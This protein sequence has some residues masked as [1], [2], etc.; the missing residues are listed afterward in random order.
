MKVFLGMVAA[1]FLVALPAA[2]QMPGPGPA[3]PP[4]TANCSDFPSPPTLPNGA[5]AN[6]A[7]MMRGTEEYGAWQAATIAKKAACREDISALQTQ[8]AAEGIAT[9]VHYPRPIHLQ[10]AMA[11]S[12]GREGDLPVS[13]QLCKEVLCLP[14][15]PELPLDAVE[16]IAGLVRRFA[17]SAR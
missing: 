6:R 10:P 17:A 7:D 15:Y 1:A 8:L 4:L 16:E 2:A 13:E 14:L 9:A 5:S 12:G 11:L 3:A